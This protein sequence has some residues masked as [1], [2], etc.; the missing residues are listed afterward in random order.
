MESKEQPELRFSGFNDD[1]KELRLGD[2]TNRVKGNDGR[3]DLPTL[4]ISAGAGW[5]DQR[6][7]FSGNIAGK[8]QKNYTLLKK[9]QLSYNHGNS[10][11]AKYG[12]VFELRTY[13]EALVPRVYHSFEANSIIVPDFI[14][15]MFATKKPDRE[16]GKLISSG[17]RMDGLLNINYDDFMGIKIEVPSIDEQKDISKFLRDVDI[18][19]SLHQ[20]ELTTLKQTKQ[21][22]LQKMFP[23]EG[24]KVPEVRFPEYIEPWVKCKLGEISDIKTGPF[25][26]TLHAEDYVL[27]GVPIITTEHFKSGN[28]PLSK[29]NTPQVSE[30]DYARLKSYVLKQ[31]DIV[32]SRVGSVDI[33]ALVVSNQNGWLFSGRVLRVRS[34]ESINSQ[35]LHYE[36]ST[37][38]AKNH[39]VARAVGQTMPSINTEIL[40]QTEIFVPKNINEQQ[41]IGS[42]F[43]QLD[44]TI[45]LHQQELELLQLT[46]KAFLQK[47]FV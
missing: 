7:R 41:K 14:E 21:G 43:K 23:K 30:R 37:T 20:Q 28:L 2:V 38:R 36:L 40:K 42:F 11:L 3:M 39:V 32:F 33:N 9:G 27:D 26:S 6:E 25:G 4:T 1:W 22:F 5:L 12:A 34:E 16:L 24:E 35:Y 29:E 17:A 45:A 31:D 15:Y 8:E 18:T 19:I 13:E 47:L 44:E 10:K 46:K